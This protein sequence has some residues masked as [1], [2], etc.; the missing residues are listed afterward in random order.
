MTVQVKKVSINYKGILLDP[1]WVIL[2]EKSSPP[3]MPLL[4][5]TYLSVNGCVYEV[6]ELEERSTFNSRTKIFKERSVSDAT[7]RSYAYGLA[8]FLN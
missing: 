5:M 2:D 4:Y 1:L 3:I 8:K 6:I 7:I